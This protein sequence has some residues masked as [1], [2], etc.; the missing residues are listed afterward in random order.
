MHVYSIPFLYY[1]RFLEKISPLKPKKKKKLKKRIKKSPTTKKQ[2]N[3]PKTD[4]ISTNQMQKNS[5]VVYR[6]VWSVEF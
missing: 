2:T 5:L 1:S 6:S 4:T 3:E